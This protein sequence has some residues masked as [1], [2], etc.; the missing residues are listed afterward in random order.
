[1]TGDGIDWIASGGVKVSDIKRHRGVGTSDH[2]P[3]TFTVTKES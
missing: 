2:D 3:V 1:V